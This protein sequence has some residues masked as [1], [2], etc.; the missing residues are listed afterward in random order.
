MRCSS[1]APSASI[2]SRPAFVT[3]AIRPSVG[4]DGAVSEVI[5]VQEGMETFLKRGW[6]GKCRFARRA[7][8]VRRLRLIPT[9]S[10]PSTSKRVLLVSALLADEFHP[11]LAFFGRDTV[12][13]AAF[14][15]GRLDA[16]VALLH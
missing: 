5:W 15:T 10:A 6:T 2:A 14:A 16:G 11:R 3:I 13:R 12:R 9:C 8:T 7:K 4:Q 1:A